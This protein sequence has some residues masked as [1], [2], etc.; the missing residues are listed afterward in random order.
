M[1]YRIYKQKN[2]TLESSGKSTPKIEYNETISQKRIIA[3]LADYSGVSEGIVTTVLTDFAVILNRHLRNGD[4]VDLDD[5]GRFKLKVQSKAM[6][7]PD[8]FDP[9]THIKGHKCLFSSA[10]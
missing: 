1:K 8:E 6:N 7:S 5:I 3:E 9:R 2:K 10:H 4:I